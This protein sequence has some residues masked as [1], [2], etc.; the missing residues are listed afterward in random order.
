MRTARR[1]AVAESEP[2]FQYNA[3]DMKAPSRLGATALTAAAAA[4]I[5][6]IGVVRAQQPP[7]PP[8]RPAQ[9][10][11]QTPAPPGAQPPAQPPDPGGRGGAP[12]A[13]P[14]VPV[15]ASSVGA[16]PQKFYGQYVSL[17]GIVEES[18]SPTAFSVDQDAKK[19]DGKEVLVVAPR[20]HE[21]VT[22]NSYIT[23]IGEVVQPDMAEIAKKMKA[24]TSGLTPE[25][26]A[27]HS[28]RPVIVAT[29]VINAALNDLAKFIPPPMTP[30][31]AAYDKVMKQVG[32]ANNAM[33]KGLEASNTDLV[34]LQTTILTKAFI[35][36]E[37]FWKKRGKADALKFAQDARKASEAIEVAAVA[38]NWGDVKTHATT[39]GQQCQSCHGV[40]RERGEDG[41]FFM[42]PGSQ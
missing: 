3:L 37:A 5:V 20:L 19:N 4:L 7:R 6:S 38:G 40:Y 17:H 25:I 22:P 15:T 1:E 8:D 27:K 29:A 11:A 33:R 31:E 28:G 30:E 35:E 26:L 36:V 16:N 32:P 2:P 14:I 39:L 9:P 18:L 23:V 24:G 10:A 21:P 34:K 13:R 41:S 12:P 42:K